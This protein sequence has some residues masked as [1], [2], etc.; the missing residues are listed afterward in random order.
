MRVHTIQIEYATKAAHNL[1]YHLSHS[2]AEY[3][4]SL[5]LLLFFCCWCARVCGAFFCPVLLWSTINTKYNTFSMHFFWSYI[6]VCLFSICLYCFTALRISRGNFHY[7]RDGK[8][9]KHQD[10]KKK[11]Q[12]KTAP[13]R[14]SIEIIEKWM[15]WMETTATAT[16]TAA[17]ISPNIMQRYRNYRI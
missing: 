6:N 1:L 10:S 14:L 12:K 11:K 7:Y 15:K 9:T 17:K 13:K 5:W 16:A 8:W 4:V 3:I 2:L